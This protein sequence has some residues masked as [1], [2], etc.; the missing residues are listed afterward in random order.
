LCSHSIL[1]GFWTPFWPFSLS[2]IA[3]TLAW[4]LLA[5][6]DHLGQF[7]LI[8][9]KKL[10]LQV[11]CAFY[12]AAEYSGYDCEEEPIMYDSP[13]DNFADLN[14]SPDFEA[15][16]DLPHQRRSSVGRI[17]E[18]F[19]FPAP[20]EEAHFSPSPM[21]AGPAS[22]RGNGGHDGQ[23]NHEQTDQRHLDAGFQDGHLA[24]NEGARN[25]ADDEHTA[26]TNLSDLQRSMRALSD[27]E[28]A[29]IGLTDNS[30][31]RTRRGR[32]IFN[33]TINNAG[34]SGSLEPG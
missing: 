29:R 21:M 7:G 4:I 12:M 31:F 34:L 3:S 16:S 9:S 25:H 19:A 30:P 24:I 1:W 13:E 28:D 6:L 14:E 20:E 27:R 17:S 8:S 10:F 2:H 33:A 15:L 23:A 32:E 18:E 26:Q 5:A 11:L 22:S